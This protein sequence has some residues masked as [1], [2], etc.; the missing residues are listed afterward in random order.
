MS[1]YKLVLLFCPVA[2][3]NLI[4]VG[5]VWGIRFVFVAYHTREI[6]WTRALHDAFCN[7]C[8]AVTMKPVSRGYV[9]HRPP[10]F[11]SFFCLC[12]DV[13]SAFKVIS[14]VCHI[15]G[16]TFGLDD[17]C[18]CC[19]A[20]ANG[21]HT[22][23]TC[24]TLSFLAPCCSSATDGGVPVRPPPPFVCQRAYSFGEVSENMLSAATS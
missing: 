7:G 21:P 3:R 16:S 18:R 13:S 19:A 23:D 2:N 15:A 24:I 5:G 11:S 8:W 1:Q 12:R 4:G 6:M 14:R 20:A 9:G 22:K 17:C 10:C